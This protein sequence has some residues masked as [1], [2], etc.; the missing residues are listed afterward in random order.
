MPEQANFVQ[1]QDMILEF[2]KECGEYERLP[3]QLTEQMRVEIGV[4]RIEK[5]LNTNEH[6]RASMDAMFTSIILE[7]WLFFEA[8]CSDLWAAGV[9]NGGPVISARV[10]ANQTWESGKEQMLAAN[11]IGVQSN[12]KTQPGSYRREIGQVSF[13]RL[14]SIIHYFKIAFGDDAGKIF[15]QTAA[16]YVRALN[17]VRNCIAH[18]A[19]KVDAQFKGA[20]GERYAEFAN[21]KSGG[22]LVLDGALVKK[23]RNAALE[24]GLELLRLV[25]A[26]LQRGD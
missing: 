24:V 9:D 18:S 20:V 21:L 2:A 26:D 11:A 17:A 6:M 1:T 12:A 25:D 15:D 7:S 13:Q 8:L 10:L 4:G 14:R 23:L 19:G 3:S 5:L 22:R 16:G